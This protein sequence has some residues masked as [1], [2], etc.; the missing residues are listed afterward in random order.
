MGIDL[1]F[2]SIVEST[3]KSWP[4]CDR[5][6]KRLQKRYPVES[7]GVQ[8]QERSGTLGMRGKLVLEASCHGATEYAD[9]DIPA[10]FTDAKVLTLFARLAFFQHGGRKPTYEG[11]VRI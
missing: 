6:T 11:I 5:C 3:P 2:S 7:F 10:W 4:I 8:G 1:G 9:V